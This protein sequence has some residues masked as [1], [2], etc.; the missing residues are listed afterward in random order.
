MRRTDSPLARVMLFDEKY[1][2]QQR[3]SQLPKRAALLLIFLKR[4]AG[5]KGKTLAAAD[6]R[7]QDKRRTRCGT[8]NDNSC[9]AETILVF[10]EPAAAVIDGS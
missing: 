6:Q 9:E 5:E 3:T 8:C 4:R 2:L 1:L 10:D 7:R